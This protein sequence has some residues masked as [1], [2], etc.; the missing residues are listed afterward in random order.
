MGRRWQI[1][2]IVFLA[3]GGA[4]R[5][6]QY[7]SRVSLWHDELAIARN[8]QDRDLR[9]LT[10]RPLDHRQVAPVGFL[11]AVKVATQML[12]VNELGL[13]LLPWLAGTLSLPLFWLVAAR[14]A[15]GASLLAGVA[16]FATSPALVWYGASVKQY[17]TDLAVSLLLV[18]LALWIRE[19]PGRIQR[20]A[21]AG[22]SGGVAILFSH[23][24]IV[25]AFVL[26]CLLVLFGSGERWR[27]SRLSLS[28][29][30]AGWGAG[31]LIAAGGAIRLLA[32]C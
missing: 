3:L 21:V 10:T 8:I 24:A 15:S 23:P 19:H 20:A 27:A 4:L 32:G 2:L 7:L 5:T 1:A 11:V 30:G 31:A 26:G 16:I 6:I 18:W 22:A 29:L 12:G 14:F 13:R 17:G 9:G 28:L 25:T